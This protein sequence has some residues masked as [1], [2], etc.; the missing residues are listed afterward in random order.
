MDYD[1]LKIF[2]HLTET[3][4]FG[5]TSKKCFISASGLSR[6]I[7]RM[8][9]EIGR[10]LFIRDN[11][12]VSITPAGLLMKEYAKD[13]LER[14]RIFKEGTANN[15]EQLHG[16]LNIYCSVTA[17]YGILQNVLNSFRVLYP[18]VHIKLQTGEEAKAIQMVQSRS[19]DITIAA[20]PDMLPKNLEFILSMV[21]PL[22]FIAPKS[23]C[24]VTNE[25]KKDITKWWDL[26]LIL[27]EHGLARKRVDELFRKNMK[28]INIYADVTG[29]EAILAMVSLGCGIGVV[30][31]LVLLQS[32]LRNEVQSID[33][34]PKLKPYHV[35]F[36][37]N[38]SRHNPLSVQAFWDIIRK[39][40][41]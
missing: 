9:K 14:W 20:K 2:L 15:R 28:K 18:Y 41:K 3:M 29:N 7:Q 16:D 12:S 23:N 5:N 8:E 1:S 33:I 38:K 30:P 31:E 25:L 40:N 6:I 21:T 39:E 11:R 36:C 37:I 22:L 19:V 26:P 17:S 13:S 34:R 32:P 4:H 24:F 27:P 35:G 10:E